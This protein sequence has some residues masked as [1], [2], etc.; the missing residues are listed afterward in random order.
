M[1]SGGVTSDSKGEEATK[2]VLGARD[3]KSPEEGGVQ[4]VFH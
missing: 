3:K 1:N 4:E 2:P